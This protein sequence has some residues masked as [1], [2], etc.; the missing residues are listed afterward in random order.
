VP[1]LL[2]SS[3]EARVERAVQAVITERRAELERLVQA[4]VDHELQALTAELLAQQL[5]NGNGVHAAD[6]TPTT[7]TCRD[8]RRDLEPAQYEKG[9]NV[10]RRCRREALARS[11]EHRQAAATPVGEE[12][13]RQPEP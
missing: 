11:R 6:P 12:P 1:E 3:L 7:K 8:C 9:R 13:P 2:V 10:C 4:R 5:T